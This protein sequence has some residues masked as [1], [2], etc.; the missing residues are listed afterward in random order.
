[1]LPSAE[2]ALVELAEPA[3]IAITDAS[4]RGCPPSP[5]TLPDKVPR[6]GWFVEDLEGFPCSA[7]G[8]LS[9]FCGG[10]DV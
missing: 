6:E 8:R 5:I 2:K 9:R 4:W 1:M 10:F 7:A 3:G